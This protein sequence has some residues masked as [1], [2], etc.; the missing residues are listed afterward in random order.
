MEWRFARSCPPLGIETL[1]RTT[2]RIMIPP[3]GWHSVVVWNKKRNENDTCFAFEPKWWSS[4]CCKACNTALRS[5][6]QPTRPTIRRFRKKNWKESLFSPAVERQFRNEVANTSCCDKRVIRGTVGFSIYGLWSQICNWKPTE[7]QTVHSPAFN[8]RR[9]RTK[10]PLK[11]TC[12]MLHNWVLPHSLTL[13][14]LGR[15]RKWPTSK[16]KRHVI[17]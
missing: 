4:I 10:R 1:C 12:F 15:G 2:S 5:W 14:G 6:I 16:R 17:A 13:G 3:A 11:P 8:C 9:H 7:K